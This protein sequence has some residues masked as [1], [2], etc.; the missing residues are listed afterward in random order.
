MREIVDKMHKNMQKQRLVE[1]NE[2]LKCSK[3][4]F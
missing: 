1:T 4:T 3:T 2:N